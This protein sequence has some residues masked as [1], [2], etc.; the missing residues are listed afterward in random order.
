[1]AMVI[2][3]PSL[4][5]VIWA[6]SDL[7]WC[8]WFSFSKLTKK[9][10]NGECADPKRKA[11]GFDR[12]KKER[13]IKKSNQVEYVDAVISVSKCS[14]SIELVIKWL[15]VCVPASALAFL[16]FHSF[17]GPFLD[18]LGSAR[19]QVPSLLLLLLPGISP[20][21]PQHVFISPAVEMTVQA[22]ASSAR[23]R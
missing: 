18:L 13:L 10:L 12:E 20:W 2:R 3:M 17:S 1:M 15:C 6:C 11:T 7:C 4:C 8:C 23:V 9:W 22:A 14:D 21:S 19:W 5:T 16:L